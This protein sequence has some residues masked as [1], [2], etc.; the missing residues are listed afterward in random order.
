MAK[1]L[2]KNVSI[3]YNSHVFFISWDIYAREG[4]PAFPLSPLNPACVGSAEHCVNQ[5]SLLKDGKYRTSL[6]AYAQTKTNAN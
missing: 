4:I 6:F 3:N 2:R 1:L 5:V